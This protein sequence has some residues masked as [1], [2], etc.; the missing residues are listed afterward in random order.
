M[1]KRQTNYNTKLVKE[2]SAFGISA[3]DNFNMTDILKHIKTFNNCSELEIELNKLV[4]YIYDGK[5]TIFF[6]EFRQFPYI[7]HDNDNSADLSGLAQNYTNSDIY[8][9]KFIKKFI[10]Y[11]DGKYSFFDVDF[12]IQN[13]KRI[14]FVEYSINNMPIDEVLN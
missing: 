7:T 4:Y 8:L 2:L 12:I 14:E 1:F 11:K 3:N 9:I 13:T 5:K 10:V 6:H